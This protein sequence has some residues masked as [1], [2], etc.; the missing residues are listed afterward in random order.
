MPLAVAPDGAR[1]Y[2][3]FQGAGEPLLLI[4]GQANDHQWNLVHHPLNT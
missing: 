1:I 3:E 4:A 2:Y